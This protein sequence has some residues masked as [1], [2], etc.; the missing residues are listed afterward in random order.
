LSHAKLSIYFDNLY[1]NPCHYHIHNY[2]KHGFFIT[3]MTQL[4][5]FQ[6]TITPYG[7]DLMYFITVPITFFNFHT[8]ALVYDYIVKH[9]MILP[10]YINSSLPFHTINVLIIMEFGCTTPLVRYTSTNHQVQSKVSSINPYNHVYS[11]RA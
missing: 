2:A 11:R 1:Y 9:C 6:L 8:I 7:I 3:V 5:G 10:S 4:Y